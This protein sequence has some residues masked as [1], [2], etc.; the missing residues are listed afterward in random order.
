MTKVLLDHDPNSGPVDMEE[1]EILDVERM[2]FTVTRVED[3]PKQAQPEQ[4]SQPKQKG[5]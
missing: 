1:A 4:G 2:G 3:R 5:N